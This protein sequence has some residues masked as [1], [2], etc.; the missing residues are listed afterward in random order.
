[1]LKKRLI[2][3]LTGKMDPAL[4]I[5]PEKAPLGV[6]RYSFGMTKPRALCL[7]W[8]FFRSNSN[9]SN[10]VNRPW[11]NVDLHTGNAFFILFMFRFT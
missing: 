6:T 4:R 7:Y 11:L 9:D 3:Q 8:C 10:S 2:T 5:V 1:M